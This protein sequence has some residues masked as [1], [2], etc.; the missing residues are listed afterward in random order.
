MSI[1]RWNIVENNSNMGV[2]YKKEHSRKKKNEKYVSTL[3][4]KIVEKKNT[5]T[6]MG[7]NIKEE[8]S[9]K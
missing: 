8:H 3:G 5:H 9:R 7:V 6:N 2:N 1:L 4:R